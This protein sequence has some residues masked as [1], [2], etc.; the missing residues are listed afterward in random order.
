MPQVRFTMDDKT[1]LED[2]LKLELHKYEEEVKNIVDKAV[3]EMSMEKVLKELHNTW[4]TLEF[5]KET[6]ERTKLS[7]LKISGETIE[8]LEENQVCTLLTFFSL[9]PWSRDEKY[10]R[11]NYKICWIPN[12]SLTSSTKWW[13]GKRSSA[14]QT[15]R[16]TPGFKSNEHGY[17]WRAFSSVQKI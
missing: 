16:S 10:R 9:Q 1:T 2:L 3:K 6:H 11:Y 14:M 4:D 5:D 17:I 7:V 8:M 12:T 13:T 15:P